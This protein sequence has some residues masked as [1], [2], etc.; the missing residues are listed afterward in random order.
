MANAQST[1][2]QV[3]SYSFTANNLFQLSLVKDKD[4]NRPGYKKQFFCFLTL[5]PGQ[6]TQTGRTYNFSSKINMKQNVH[7]VLSLAHAIRAVARGQKALIGNFSLF[8]DS[9]KSGYGG[10]GG[11]V[12]QV[13][14]N[15]Y[16]KPVNQ[17]Q[18]NQQERYVSIGFR[19]GENK[20]IG[21]SFNIPDA[22]ACADVLE[23]VGKMGLKLEASGTQTSFAK[24]PPADRGQRTSNPHNPSGPPNPMN[25][26][27]NP[28]NPPG[29][30]GPQNSPDNVVDN[31]QQGLD[32]A[33]GSMGG[34]P[35]PMEDDIPF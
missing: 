10:Q 7:N 6:Q 25:G 28:M 30:G 3:Y 9:S 20:P 26:P 11:A 12:K 24:N 17:N 19:S 2:E 16:L 27:P 34:P 18:Q 8:T 13:F 4:P 35:N 32:N 31:F 23:F 33:A 15:E 22:L 5:A 21:L 29:P 1:L 14:V